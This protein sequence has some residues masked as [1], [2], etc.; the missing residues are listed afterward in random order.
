MRATDLAHVMQMD[1]LREMRSFMRM[2]PW[3]TTP[4]DMLPELMEKMPL[5]VYEKDGEFVVKANLPGVKKE[6]VT[7][8]LQG[9]MLTINAERKEEKEIKK[10][11]YYMKEVESG[12]WTRSIR[13]PNYLMYDKTQA[14]YTDGMLTVR[15]PRNKET[16][17]TSIDVK[18]T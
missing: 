13:L 5:D 7:I 9:D 2:F 12:C 1:P 10:E 18:V 8:H 14:S 4:T 17:P 15:I 16:A 6:D 3:T 11:D